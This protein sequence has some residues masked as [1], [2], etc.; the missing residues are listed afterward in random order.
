MDHGFSTRGIR[1]RRPVPLFAL[2]LVLV[3]PFPGLSQSSLKI[4]FPYGPMGLNSMP[5]IVAKEANIFEKNGLNVD[6]IFV[7]VSTVMI[8]SMLSGSANI[9]G[10]GGPAVIS[11]VLRGGD[12]IQIAATVPYFTQSLM[13]PPQITELGGLR[14]KKVGITRFGAVTDLAL[15]AILE[16]NNIKDVTILQMGGLAE[17]MAGLSRGSVDGSM[18]SPPHTFSLLKQGFRELVSP[19]DLRKLGVG[20]LTNGMVARRSY[21]ASNRDVVV[22]MIKAT[23]EGTKL[24]TANEALTKKVI[25]KYLHVDDPELLHQSYL[26]VVEN[27][28]RDPAVPE[29]AMQWMAQQLAQLNL[30]DAKSLQNTRTS[31]FFDNSY[32]EELKRSGFLENLWK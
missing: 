6:M 30:V 8:Q 10:L 4:P 1:F 2:F 22:R 23:V 19:K 9:G 11:N 21:A 3:G 25:S 5:W 28:A 31:A 7:G 14:G 32:V 24:M 29:G 18:V 15:R 26:Y 20:F 27:F 12:I 17:T 13:V 16:R